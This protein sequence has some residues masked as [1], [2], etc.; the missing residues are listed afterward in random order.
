MAAKTIDELISLCK[1]R[2]FIFQSNEIYGGLQG[3]YDYGPLGVE[4]KKNIKDSWWRELVYERDDIEGLDASILTKQTVLNYS[5]H[6]ET[7]TD[8][9]VDCKNCNARWR[10]DHLEKKVCPGCGSND[11][12]EPRPFNLMFKTNIGPI[13]DGSSFAY[14]RP[15]TA[16]QIFVNFKNV[17]DSTSRSL[18]FG[19]AQIGKAFRNEI[20]LKSFIFRV[21]EFEQMELEFF[22][23]PGED[24]EWH[25]FWVEERI[26]WWER[27]GLSRDNLELY[28]VPEDELAHYSKATVDIMYKFPHGTE[29]L[30]GVAN[31]TDFDLGSHSKN[32]DELNICAK[33]KHNNDSN[34]K[35]A[36]KEPHMKDWVVPFVIEPSAGVDRA[37]L[38]VL[39]EAYHEEQIENSSRLVLKLKPHLSPIKAAV[40]PLKKNNPEMVELAKNIKKQLQ[41]K[42][43]GRVLLENTGNIGKSYRKHD[44]VGTP[45]CITVDF[46][47]LEDG[48][49]TVRDRDTMSQERIPKENIEQYFLTYF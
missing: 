8:P 15:E 41:S 17:V 34:S 48:S 46:E 27:Q 40:I 7:F 43:L 20:T 37:V 47:S 28:E 45:I 12:T 18:P 19:I 6:E 2:G 10:E 42:G 25:K 9:L 3:L 5:G 38:A 31:R 32:Q 21:R 1:R 39:N 49:V 16:Q 23:T 30:E 22:V 11:L 4:L 14:L 35:L 13:D 29:E 24:E 26:N 44:E 36:I 33:T